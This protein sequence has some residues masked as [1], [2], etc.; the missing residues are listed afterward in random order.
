[1]NLLTNILGSILDYSDY[2]I[3]MIIGLLSDDKS[4]ILDYYDLQ[5]LGY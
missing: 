4:P 3:I 5:Y 2:W 1:M